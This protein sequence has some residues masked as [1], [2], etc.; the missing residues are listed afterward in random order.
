MAISPTELLAVV[1]SLGIQ[2]TDNLPGHFDA[3]GWKPE[4]TLIDVLLSLPD[5]ELAHRFLSAFFQVERL[6]PGTSTY[7]HLTMG[8]G[9]ADLRTRIMDFAMG[10]LDMS[11]LSPMLSVTS[12]RSSLSRT[13]STQPSPPMPDLDL[14]TSTEP[15][16]NSTSTGFISTKQGSYEAGEHGFAVPGPPRLVQPVSTDTSPEVLDDDVFMEDMAPLDL[17]FQDHAD[18]DPYPNK[19]SILISSSTRHPAERLDLP[20]LADSLQSPDFMSMA[21]LRDRAAQTVDLQS[22]MSKLSI[23]LPS[24]VLGKTS[25]NSIG[26]ALQGLSGASG[27]GVQSKAHTKTSDGASGNLARILGNGRRGQ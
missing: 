13:V 20:P 11:A 25:R 12:C 23:G 18:S 2:A 21:A 22:A 19:G 16:P 5:S 1:V 15:T 26:S 8:A 7:P 9:G 10:H 14:S 3:L 17:L 6:C 24:A 27:R 4:G